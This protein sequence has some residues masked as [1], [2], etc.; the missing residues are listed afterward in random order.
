MSL[1]DTDT[2]IVAD[3][4]SAGQL[5]TSLTSNLSSLQALMGN[6][7]TTVMD[8]GTAVAGTMPCFL[9]TQPDAFPRNVQQLL[10]MPM[11]T[12]AV[13]AVC[14]TAGLQAADPRRQP[15][16]AAMLAAT[17]A[18]ALT[19]AKGAVQQYQDR[20]DEKVHEAAGT[21]LATMNV[22]GEAMAK[23]IQSVTMMWDTIHTSTTSGRVEHTR[24]M[25]DIKAT[26]QKDMKELERLFAEKE[27][28]NNLLMKQNATVQEK[29]SGANGIDE[30][31]QEDVQKSGLVERM[32]RSCVKSVD[33][34]IY[35]TATEGGKTVLKKA[36]CTERGSQVGT[37]F[38]NTMQKERKMVDFFRLFDT[39]E[40][41]G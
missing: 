26:Y 10:S 8:P 20:Y 5:I 22:D 15:V 32:V 25:D 28:L 21:M 2:T 33:S 9:D 6:V 30:L 23:K 7:A 27:K 12:T 24:R 1:S 34:Q 36:Q 14:N 37:G 40:S 17:T 19:Y 13:T 31:T 11:F 29:I 35:P 38:G 18:I 41:G 39:S 4:A 3:L 16:H